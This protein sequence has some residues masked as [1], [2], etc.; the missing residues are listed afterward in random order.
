M[1][2]A[3][4]LWLSKVG[5]FNSFLCVFT[6][7]SR[8]KLLHKA[9]LTLCIFL[10]LLVKF[11]L[12]RIRSYLCSII[13]YVLLIVW[14]SYFCVIRRILNFLFNCFFSSHF[15]QFVYVNLWWISN[16]IVI[17]NPDLKNPGPR[18][19]S[20]TFRPNPITIL[21]WNPNS[22][23]GHNVIRTRCIEAL[24]EIKIMI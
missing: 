2:I 16:L 8:F 10:Y 17:R 23:L 14:Y 19:A 9:F 24:N 11:C 12:T 22:I 15:S 13:F 4:E 20:S 21:H 3:S 18:S 6:K 5:T 1:P 7:P